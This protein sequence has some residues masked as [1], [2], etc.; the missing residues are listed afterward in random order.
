MFNIVIFAFSPYGR[1]PSAAEHDTRENAFLDTL[2]R[3][4]GEWGVLRHRA[5]WDTF[6]RKKRLNYAVQQ[7]STHLAFL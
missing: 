6:N 4:R 5:G 1:V 3:D 7:L 2:N